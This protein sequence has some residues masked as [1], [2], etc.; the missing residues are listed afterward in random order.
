MSCYTGGRL[1]PQD[2]DRSGDDDDRSSGNN[3]RPGNDDDERSI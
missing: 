2:N 3:E 1:T